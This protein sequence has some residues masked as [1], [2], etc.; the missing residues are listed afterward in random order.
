M[1]RLLRHADLTIMGRVGSSAKLGLNKDF[2]APC[3]GD[4]TTLFTAASFW[5]ERKISGSNLTRLAPILHRKLSFGAKRVKIEAR[6]FSFGP[7]ARGCDQRDTIPWTWRK[8][9]LV[10]PQFGDVTTFYSS[11][12]RRVRSDR[13]SPSAA[14]RIV[15]LLYQFVHR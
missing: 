10:Q 14:G 6:D 4:C 13:L 12:S 8:K 15:L 9:I 5:P 1:S 7:E 3:P 11:R 2:L